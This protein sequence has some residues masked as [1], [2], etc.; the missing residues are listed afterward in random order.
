MKYQNIIFDLD[1]TLSSIEGIDELGKLRNMGKRIKR[2]TREAMS[3]RLPFGEVFIHRL[4]L[5]KPT[6][7]ELKIIGKL[8]KNN[9]TS[10]YKIT[11]KS[12]KVCN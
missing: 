2:L 10:Q 11:G 9:I 7:N 3:G 8:Y 6:K 1:S 4:E 5:I 12:C